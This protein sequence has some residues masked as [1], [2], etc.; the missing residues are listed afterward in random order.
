MPEDERQEDA[1]LVVLCLWLIAWTFWALALS[2]R[3]V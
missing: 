2:P 1:G 3:T